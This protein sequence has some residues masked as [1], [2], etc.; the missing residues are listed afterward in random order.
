MSLDRSIRQCPRAASLRCPPGSVL[1][2]ARDRAIEGA[3]VRIRPRVGATR[4]RRW[5]API[6]RRWMQPAGTSDTITQSGWILGVVLLGLAVIAGTVAVPGSPVRAWIQT[7]ALTIS[8]ISSVQEAPNTASG[9]ST[10]GWVL[11]SNTNTL[12]ATTVDGTPA[13]VWNDPTVGYHWVW[14]YVSVAN[15]ATYRFTVELAGTGEAWLNVWNGSANIPAS[16]IYL[17]GGWQTTTMVVTMQESPGNPS[18]PEI[19]IATTQ[20]PSTVDFQQAT[21]VPVS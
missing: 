20:A 21:V 18:P 16:P 11:S 2:R 5:I 14:E 10:Q 1:P 13:L 8:T 12:T 17:T 15:N 4:V 6:L 19:Q 7:R 9:G 3:V